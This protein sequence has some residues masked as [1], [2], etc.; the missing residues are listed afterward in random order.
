MLPAQIQ[1][2]GFP[3]Q[4]R[5]PQTLI[6]AGRNPGNDALE[7]VIIDNV[8]AGVSIIAT[9]TFRSRLSTPGWLE[10]FRER[11]AAHGGRVVVIWVSAAEPTIRERILARQSWRDAWKLANWDRWVVAA[12]RPAP[13]GVDA[14]ITNDGDRS[15]FEEALL[16]ACD[17]LL[18]VSPRPQRTV[19]G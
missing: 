10:A 14:V 5:S 4:D 9:N 11:V 17:T 3:A 2:A 6:R 13:R 12:L 8:S 18:G 19:L 7:A 16:T 15:A 1:A